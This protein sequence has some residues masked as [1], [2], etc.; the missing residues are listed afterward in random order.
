MDSQ[1]KRYGKIKN[2]NLIIASR[3]VRRDD[4]LYFDDEQL[5]TENGYKPVEYKDAPPNKD[6]YNLV[7]EWKDEGNKIV[8]EWVYQPIHE[9]YS[10]RLVQAISSFCRK[11]VELR[12]GLEKNYENNS[13][14]IQAIIRENNIVE[15]IYNSREEKLDAEAL[16]KILHECHLEL[17]K[18]IDKLGLLDKI[19]ELGYEVWNEYI[20]DKTKEHTG[21]FIKNTK[22]L[23]NLIMRDA[24]VMPQEIKYRLSK[25]HQLESFTT[26]SNTTTYYMSF[27][28][29][30]TL[31][32]EV[33]LKTIRLICMHEKKW[34]VSN[35]SILAADVLD[36]KTT[37]ELHMK[38]V[39]KKIEELAWGSYINKLEFLESKGIVIDEEHRKLFK[40]TILYLSLKRNAMVHNEGLWNAT[41]KSK[42]KQTE[43]F[44]KVT[45]GCEVDTSIESYKEASKN[46]Q[47][48]V[49]YLYKKVCD[50][51]HLLFMIDVNYYFEVEEN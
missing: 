30:F 12:H 25:I 47:Q 20:I 34:L 45:I 35:S 19:K 48:A 3:I 15:L 16:L 18:F 32:D 7:S 2:E 42:L 31:F 36:C 23:T 33:L 21:D 40:D 46:I 17:P 28:Y 50:K 44:D 49:D 22:E 8:Q 14:E 10:A 11:S 24:I 29:M 26:L 39:D 9:D 13:L 43:Y 51:F 6:G 4:E 1:N 37:D 27:I 41:I 5:Y 38:L